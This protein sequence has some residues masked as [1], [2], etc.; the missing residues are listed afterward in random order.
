MRRALLLTALVCGTVP[1][2]FAQEPP[3][4]VAPLSVDTLFNPA[5]KVE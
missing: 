3:A 4:P 2:L 1:A 5:K